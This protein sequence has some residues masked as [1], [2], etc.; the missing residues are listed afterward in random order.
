MIVADLQRRSAWQVEVKNLTVR[1]GLNGRDES[2]YGDLEELARQIEEHGVRESLRGYSEN[3]KYVITD[4]HRRYAAIQ[5]LAAR[6]VHILRVPFAIEDRKAT[7]AEYVLTQLLS[8]SG[9]PLSAL[10]EAKN[11]ARL[12]KYGWTKEEIAVKSGF[13]MSKVAML[14][15]LDLA[16]EPM[17][18]QIRAGEVS[19]S[20][21]LA[22]VRGTRSSAE[23]VEVMEAAQA[24][25]TKESAPLKVEHVHAVKKAAKDDRTSDQIEAARQELISELAGAPWEVLT[26][27]ALEKVAAALSKVKHKVIA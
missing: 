12:Q 11:I 22:A 26:L 20:A 23:V 25:A 18:A 19:Q 9:K 2:E 21:V 4:G 24:L 27:G 14:L 5:L 6:G 10:A 8:N 15:T 16:P 13:E 7:D 3:G 17:K 1:P